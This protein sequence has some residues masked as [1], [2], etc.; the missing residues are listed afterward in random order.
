MD[1]SAADLAAR[2]LAAA[3]S[4]DGLSPRQ[5]MRA[6]MATRALMMIMTLRRG[7]VHIYFTRS[8]FTS[9]EFIRDVNIVFRAFDFFY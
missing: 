6:A 5:E 4:G 3:T 9:L 1:A 8:I 2:Q 7:C